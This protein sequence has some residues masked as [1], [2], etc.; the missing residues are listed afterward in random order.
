MRETHIPQ[1]L[2]GPD[3]PVDWGWPETGQSEHAL[4]PAPV[5]RDLLLDTVLFEERW[6]L[7]EPVRQLLDKYKKLA[8]SVLDHV[9]QKQEE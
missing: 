6:S 1:D 8:E 2:C 5:I 3:S 7:S 4:P 9:T